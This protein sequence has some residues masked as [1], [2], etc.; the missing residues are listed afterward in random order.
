VRSRRM[1][2][3]SAEDRCANLFFRRHTIE[4][5]AQSGT[6]LSAARWLRLFWRV[7]VIRD[8]LGADPRVI[9]VL[10]WSSNTLQ[11]GAV[12]SRGVYSGNG[13]HCPQRDA[14]DPRHAGN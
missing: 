11:L 2:S 13:T 8:Q 6:C 12:E 3:R 4:S 14:S 9:S 1:I 5:P 10:Y 7:V